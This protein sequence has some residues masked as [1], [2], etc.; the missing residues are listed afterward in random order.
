MC[1]IQSTVLPFVLLTGAGKDP[2]RGDYAR[3]SEEHAENTGERPKSNQR[4]SPRSRG[5]AGRKNPLPEDVELLGSCLPPASMYPWLVRAGRL[6]NGSIKGGDSDM[7]FCYGRI[8]GLR[9]RSIV[10]VRCTFVR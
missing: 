6:R 2:K 3:N 5:L 4:R 1:K 9:G 7:L 8:V 10:A